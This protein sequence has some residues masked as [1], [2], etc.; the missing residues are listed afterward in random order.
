M[1][2]VGPDGERFPVGSGRNKKAARLNAAL[3]ALD[4][5]VITGR[6]TARASGSNAIVPLKKVQL[7]STFPVPH[8][9]GRMVLQ[10]ENKRFRQDVF[11]LTAQYV[12]KTLVDLAKAAK[13][14]HVMDSAKIIAGIVMMDD[15]NKDAFVVSLATGSTFY[16]PS[17]IAS[18][19]A[20]SRQPLHPR[21]LGI[22]ERRG[23]Q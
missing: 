8:S 3:L 4:T 5:L 7:N 9:G 13:T 22:D 19:P 1:V 2:I 15:V 6:W 20:S 17:P 14:S 18:S 10:L 16:L 23:S 12:N 21:R 11:G